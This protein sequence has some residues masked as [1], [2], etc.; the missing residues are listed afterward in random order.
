M[1]TMAA[2]KLS[3]DENQHTSMV[4]RALEGIMIE[5]T[6]AALGSKK[7]MIMTPAELDI[8]AR[9]WPRVREEWIASLCP[10]D[11][12]RAARATPSPTAS[13]ASPAPSNS[14]SSA[15]GGLL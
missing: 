6:R 14:P 1:W 10:A 12:P 11:A 8:I 9:E 5:R 7:A 4:M 13:K 15:Q 3:Q 2:I